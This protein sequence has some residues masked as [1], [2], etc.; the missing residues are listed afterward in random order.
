MKTISKKLVIWGNGDQQVVNQEIIN[1]NGFE[2]IAIVDDVKENF[3]L[4]DKKIKFFNKFSNFK[5]WYEEQKNLEE[6]HFIISIGNPYGDLRIKNAHLLESIGIKPLSIKHWNSTI[7][8]TAQLS[9][10]YQIMAGVIVNAEACIGNQVILNTGSIIE[11]HVRIGKGCEVGPGAV[12][13]GRVTIGDNV[14]VGANA[15]ILPRI[16]IGSNVVIGAG[17]VVTKNVRNE[18]VVV[19][20]PAKFLKNFNF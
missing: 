10:G 16:E 5:N 1:E 15:V 8:K 19:G 9:E 4:N 3:N 11:H 17:S 18:E 13:L 12:I 14:W 6:T 20:N 7:S 2:I